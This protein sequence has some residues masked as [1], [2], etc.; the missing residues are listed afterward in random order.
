MLCK[1]SLEGKIILICKI[2]SYLPSFTHWY[3][4]LQKFNRRNIVSCY[5][6]SPNKNHLSPKSFRWVLNKQMKT[7]FEDMTIVST[8]IQDT[9]LH[10][11]DRPGESQCHDS[12]RYNCSTALHC[13]DKAYLVSLKRAVY[14]LWISN[15]FL[16]WPSM[17]YL[18][19]WHAGPCVL[20]QVV[21]GDVW[22]LQVL[23][24][25]QLIARIL[26]I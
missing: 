26:E 2:E 8:E 19:V 15:N 17:H 1:K 22:W 3:S 4:I 20:C 13:W 16:P 10:T 21:S 9:A 23:H 5:V 6:I 24:L 7:C 14:I 11:G 18:K 12:S 25:K